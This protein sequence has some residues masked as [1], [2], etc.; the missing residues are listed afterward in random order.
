MHATTRKT[1]TWLWLA[2]LAMSL[3]PTAANAWWNTDWS[4]RKQ[5]TINTGPKGANIAQA[6]G[7]AA[8]LI[9]LHSA[10]FQFDDAQQAGNDL[11]FVAADDKTPLHFHIESF[12]AKAELATVWVDI[13]VMPAGASQDIW[14]YYGN[15]KATP[16]SDPRATFDV[17]YTLVYHFDSAAGQPPGDKTAYANN[18]RSAAGV[19]TSAI[20]GK[21]VRMTGASPIQVAA[22]PSLA[23]TEGGAFSF[24]GWVKP[25]AAQPQAAIFARRDGK[26]ALIIGLAQGVPFV[27]VRG[28]TTQRVSRGAAPFPTASG[29]PSPLPRATAH[30]RSTL[31]AS[32][33]ARRSLPY[34]H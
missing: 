12:D 29:A 32:K 13:P 16:G 8:L 28:A 6:A 5:I 2:V 19:D 31:T 33:P 4:Y 21:G 14:L 24:E 27:E 10:N 15:S 11:R 25:E 9:R 20:I 1:R 30:S 7:R 3:I 34:R 17:D 26:A 23:I 22:S 18:A